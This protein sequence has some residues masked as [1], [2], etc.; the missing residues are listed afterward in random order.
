MWLILQQDEPDDY[1][2]ATGETTSV[3]TFVEWAFEDVGIRLTWR[4]EG[5]DEKGYDAETGRCLVEVDAR[6]FRPTEVDQLIGDA[7]KARAKLDW[8]PEISVRDLCREMVRAD[9]EVM[10]TAPLG[11]GA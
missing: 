4:G 2:L 9:L 1:V 10:R 11:T 8:K 6:Y 3:R 7:S 5:L